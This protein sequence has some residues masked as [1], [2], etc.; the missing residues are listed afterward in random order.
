M[1]YLWH[2]DGMRL[3]RS[4]IELGIE[5]WKAVANCCDELVPLLNGNYEKRYRLSGVYDF[6]EP[7]K[8]VLARMLL[9]I[10]GRLHLRADGAIILDIGEFCDP[11]SRS[12]MTTFSPMTCGEGRRRSTSRTKSA[13]PMPRPVSITSSRK[14]TPAQRRQHPR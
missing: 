8:N 7:P 9:P 2:S 4:M 12:P 11:P 13:P 3:P 1:D 14:P 6:S 10:D 5:R